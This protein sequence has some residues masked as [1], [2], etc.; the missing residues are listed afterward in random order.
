MITKERVGELLSGFKCH[1]L[2]RHAWK[3]VGGKAS[4]VGVQRCKR[5]PA[6]REVQ[7]R[8]NKVVLGVL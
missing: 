7:L 5:C 6:K 3:R 4:T 1:V 8:E 2:R